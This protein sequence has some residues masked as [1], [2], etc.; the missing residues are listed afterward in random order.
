[1]RVLVDT[2]PLVAMLF[3]GDQFHETCTATLRELSTPLYTSWPVLTEAAWLLQKKPHL[4]ERL[5]RGQSGGL[6]QT[7]AMQDQECDNL[8]VLLA[9]YKDLRP[10]LA[11]VTLVCLAHREDIDTI[12]T[13]DRRDFSVYRTARNRPFRLLPSPE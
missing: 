10:Q 13:L 3:P 1:M 2:G 8:A 9:R 4:I 6:F 12:F 7:F 11:D 5:L